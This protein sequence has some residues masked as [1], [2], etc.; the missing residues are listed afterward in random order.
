MICYK[1]YNEL[2]GV[3]T[4]AKTL[5]SVIY[6]NM[7]NVTK[8][9][10]GRHQD[11]RKRY[12]GQHSTPG[13]IEAHQTGAKGTAAIR[14]RLAASRHTRKAQRARRQYSTPGSIEA[15][16]TGAKGTAAILHTWQHRGAPGTK[17]TGC[18]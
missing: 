2:P 8:W 15:H 9:A 16:Q 7:Y 10:P 3:G 4:A 18:K 13:S 12:N 5:K 17:K 1:V 11:G 14:P 6:Y